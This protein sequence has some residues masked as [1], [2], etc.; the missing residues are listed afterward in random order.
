M[1][2]QYR[3]TF[4]FTQLFIFAICA[5]LLYFKVS[6]AGLL[7]PFVVMQI[8]SIYGAR[9]AARLKRAGDKDSL[10]LSRVRL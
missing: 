4:V 9:W 8:G 3:R 10:P 6:F 5:A 1:W 7:V 2:E